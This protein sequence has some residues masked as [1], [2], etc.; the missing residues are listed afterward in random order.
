MFRRGDRV[1][2]AVS[3]G[4]DSLCLLHVLLELGRE[5]DLRISI[6]HL[7]HGLRG[8]ASRE[9]A[10]FVRATAV[11]LG[12]PFYLKETDVAALS[13]ETGDNLEQAGRRARQAFYRSV[14]ESGSIDRV[15][16]GHTRSD[17]AETVL[18][19]ILR[20]AGTAGLAGIRPVTPERIVRPL[21]CVDRAEVEQYLR[22]RGIP[23]RE[24]VTNSS[25][26]FAR[27]RIR[28]ELLPALVRDWNP[29]LVEGLSHLAEWALDEEGYWEAEL[30][31]LARDHLIEKGPAVLIAAG[32]L[33]AMPRA[34]A[35]RLVRKAIERVKGDLRAIDFEHT[36][37]VLDL[38]LSVEGHGRLQI[39]GID[40]FRSFDWIRL[41]PPGTDR[42]EA[43]NYRVA[44]PVPGTVR[45]PD[46]AAGI[47]LELIEKS[48]RNDCED[49]VY[50]ENVACLDWHRLSGSL[51]IR[52]WR[53]GDQYQ[54]FGH[55]G[56]E[57]IKELFQT[58]KIPLWERRHWPVLTSGDTIIWA[59]RFGPAA[60]FAAGPETRVVVAIREISNVD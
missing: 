41:A 47:R 44:A 26:A 19:R 51:E 46:S 6:L 7:N 32:E 43:R 48:E 13:R 40:V 3:G 60:Q 21:L 8:A 54:P 45:V 14:I 11:R 5:W 1:G 38:A 36:N 10:E 4:A 31:R 28:H 9:D 35:R 39:P 42:L 20:G 15:A 16:A 17:Q 30:D 50:N 37:A 56:V 58:A 49:S 53:P 33:A 27:N 22:E 59:R 12:L 25:P 24:D 52:N 2:V 23:W 57:K 55:T 18:F 29:R 34:S